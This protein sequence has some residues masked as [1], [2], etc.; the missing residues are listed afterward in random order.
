MVFIPKF[1]KTIKSATLPQRFNVRERE[2]K[3]SLMGLSRVRIPVVA[4]ILFDVYFFCV[5]FLFNLLLRTHTKILFGGS[6]HVNDDP[7]SI[8]SHAS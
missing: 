5:C 2:R 3:G 6:E 8:C 7:Y 4:K 1:L